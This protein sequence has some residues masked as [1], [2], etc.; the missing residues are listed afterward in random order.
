MAGARPPQQ[1]AVARIVIHALSL[2]HG[3]LRQGG[4]V[5]SW[6]S[7]KLR[8]VS[9]GGEERRSGGEERRQSWLSQ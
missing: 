1:L 4:S 2:L 9:V 3:G 8:S 5:Q 7:Q 6:L